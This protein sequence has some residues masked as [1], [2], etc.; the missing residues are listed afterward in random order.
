M[1]SRAKELVGIGD[2]LFSTRGGLLSLWQQIGDHFY[3][4]RAD[5]TTQRSEGEEFASEMMT[6][7]PAMA[8]R[9]L[10]NLFASILR[11]RG[12]DWFSI[13]ATDEGIDDD[14]AAREWLEWA[15]GV[16]R[17]AMYDP[18]A[19]FVRATKEADHD[20]AAF[21]QAVLSVEVDRRGPALLYRDWHIRDCAW[22]E[23]ASGKIDTL[24]RRYKPTIRELMADF[25]NVAG[26][27][28][29][30]ADKEPH[31]AILC[32]HVVV[33]ADQYDMGAKNRKGMPFVSLYV[34][35]ENE[36]VME[37]VPMGWFQYIVPRW[38]TISGSQYA[39]SPATEIC[40]PDAR[41]LQSMTL[42]LLE[43]GEKAV[44]PPSIAAQEV[45]RSDMN[46]FAGG[47]TFA[48]LEKDQKLGDVFQTISSD[49]SGIP[50]GI[51][52]A[53]KI[54]EAIKQGFFLDKLGLPEMQSKNMTAYEVRKIIEEHVR[55]SAPIFEPI[56]EEYNSPLANLT[57]EVLRTYG[58]FGP[59]DNIPEALRGAE[60]GFSFISPLREVVDEM[61]GQQLQETVQLIGAV[62][63]VD[64][65]QTA[66][67]DWTEATRDALQGIRIPAKWFSKDG[68]VEQAKAAHAQQ[69]QAQAAGQVAGVASD[70]ALNAGKAAQAFSQ[71]GVA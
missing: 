36:H 17:R 58:A 42:I 64:P 55:Q 35:E 67:I 21:G 71:A 9:E 59:K 33:P 63:Q 52:M 10:G 27:V 2:R 3:P 30:V 4:E 68:T 23:N 12:Q 44:D 34:D 54:E 62:S 56:E 51:N 45:F 65:A 40:L 41:L 70:V 22:S 32:R 15:T 16:Q 60:V 7:Y 39:R 43:A 25:K 5:F 57:F 19:T 46:F 26:E 13:H 50:L 38:Q 11:P 1:D 69:A 61:K 18:A 49:K 53:L 24:H 8:R 66:Q 14:Q 28:S 6:S 20:F 31:R 48:D 47:V 29:R 37:A